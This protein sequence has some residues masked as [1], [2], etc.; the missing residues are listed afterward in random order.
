[1]VEDTSPPHILQSLT[2]MHSSFTFP[3]DVS[4]LSTC[5][6]GLTT[7]PGDSYLCRELLQICCSPQTNYNIRRS[8]THRY[9][10]QHSGSLA[11]TTH[12]NHLYSSLKCDMNTRWEGGCGVSNSCFFL[13]H[14]YIEPLIIKIHHNQVLKKT[15]L[16][17]GPI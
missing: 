1:M 8:C 12:S 10:Q 2:I 14:T 9:P 16:C 17:L 5:P 13:H 3:A 6:R 15:K 4:V 7:A 11:R